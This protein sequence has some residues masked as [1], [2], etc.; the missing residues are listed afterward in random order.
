MGTATSLAANPEKINSSSAGVGSA[1]T[2][3]KKGDPRTYEAAAKGG[4][5]PKRTGTT[6][7]ATYKHKQQN[8][9]WVES[10]RMWKKTCTWRDPAYFRTLAEAKAAA[11]EDAAAVAFEELPREDA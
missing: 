6:D 1:H 9:V 4:R 10:K 3:F 5:H 7:G 8:I 2:R 11:D